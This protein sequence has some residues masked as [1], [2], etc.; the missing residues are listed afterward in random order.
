MERQKKEDAE[1][2]VRELKS[3]IREAQMTIN[4]LQQEVQQLVSV[5][6]FYQI[7]ST[8]CWNGINQAITLLET[9]KSGIPTVSSDQA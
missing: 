2:E 8:N 6:Q 9:L 3:T 5:V 4:L 1:G 7:N